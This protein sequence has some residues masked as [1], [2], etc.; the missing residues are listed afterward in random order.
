M[1]FLHAHRNRPL[2]D[3]I[4]LHLHLLVLLQCAIEKHGDINVGRLECHDEQLHELKTPVE[5]TAAGPVCSDLQFS[6]QILT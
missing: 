6:N 4:S 5:L 1:N 3:V 2:T